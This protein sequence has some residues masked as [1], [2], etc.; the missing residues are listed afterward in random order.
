MMTFHNR[1]VV[2]E[3][4]G[5]LNVAPVIVWDH[6]MMKIQDGDHADNNLYFLL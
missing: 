6:T 2:I 1:D 3:Q 5:P 4:E